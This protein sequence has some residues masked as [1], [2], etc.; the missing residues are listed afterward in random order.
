MGKILRARICAALTSG[1]LLCA[2]GVVE[3]EPGVAGRAVHT[4]STTIRL[5][6]LQEQFAAVARD[7]APCVVAIAASST[8]VSLEGPGGP[9]TAGQ[10]QA[11]LAETRHGVGA[12]FVIDA[13]GYVLT[14]EHVVAGREHLCVITDDRTVYPAVMVGSDRRM[15][16]AVL[17]VPARSLPVAKIASGP[18]VERGQWTITLGNPWGL[19]E[20]GELSMSVGVVSAVG[21]ALP[22]LAERDDRNYTN[23]I[24]TT[25]EV[26]P[27]N[28][29]GA[30][31]NLDGEVIGVV[32]AVSMPGVLNPHALGFA[33]PMSP[34]VVE[35]VEQ[36]KERGSESETRVRWRGVLLGAVP[37]HWRAS[38][39]GTGSGVMVL[40]VER[41]SP[42]F[43]R[44][45]AAGTIIT[46]IG[47]QGVRGV[48]DLKAA[49]ARFPQELVQLEIARAVSAAADH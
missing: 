19:A 2:A 12:G 34:Q 45:L 35:R 25:A 37:P 40:A 3:A 48:D 20:A 6:G 46:G 24:Q 14:N 13:G 11:V 4:R 7:V 15:D 36:L 49:V 22:L 43:D 41:E 28:S 23:L 10:L 38:K 44:G 18:R 33:I 9:M 29:G 17:K 27:G 31:F 26:N 16:L 47:G 32:T 8:P 42:F 21:R 5:A 39:D 1:L 30:L